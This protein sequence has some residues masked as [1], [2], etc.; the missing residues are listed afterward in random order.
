[1]T[2]EWSKHCAL[3]SLVFIGTDINALIAI[4]VNNLNLSKYYTTMFP[5]NRALLF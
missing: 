3:L 4:K 2:E 5:S 1:M